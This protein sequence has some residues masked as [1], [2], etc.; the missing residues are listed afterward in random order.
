MQVITHKRQKHGPGFG[1]SFLGQAPEFRS[2]CY[3]K[4]EYDKIGSSIVLVRLC[5]EHLRQVIFCWS[6][7]Q[8]FGSQRYSGQRRVSE[9]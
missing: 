3:I 7:H 4:A 2:Y 8:I 9:I 5:Q 1:G 6:S